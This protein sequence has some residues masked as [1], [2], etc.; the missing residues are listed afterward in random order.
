MPKLIKYTIFRTNSGYFTLAGT[1]TALHRTLL[2]T[3]N[4]KE[5]ENQI[6]NIYQAPQYQKDYFK[7]LQQKIKTYYQGSYT[8][9]TTY[10]PIEICGSQFTQKVLKA[11]RKITYAQTTTYQQLAKQANSAKAARTAGTVMANN[12]LPLIIPCHRIIKSNGETG[13]FSAGQG[14]TAKKMMLTLEKKV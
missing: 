11:C 2:P 7:P 10:P 3:P 1:K 13:A 4:A 9:F 12:P 8:D 5:A 6:R 14:T